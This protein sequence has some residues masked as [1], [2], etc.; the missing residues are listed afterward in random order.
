MRTTST[1]LL[2]CISAIAP[3]DCRSEGAFAYGQYGNG[4]WS[5][6]TSWNYETKAEASDVAMRNCNARGPNCR[7]QTTFHETCFAYAMQD[8]SNGWGTGFGPTGGDASQQALRTCQQYGVRCYVAEQ[9]CDNVSEDG[10]RAQREAERQAR[11]DQEER[12]LRE[13][14]AETERDRQAREQ[15]AREAAERQ[16]LAEEEARQ[17]TERL[18]AER[19]ATEAAEEQ[20]RQAR[21]ELDRLRTERDR[22]ARDAAKPPSVRQTP[23]GIGEVNAMLVI[24]IVLLVGILGMIL[25]GNMNKTL[26]VAIAIIIPTAVSV[27]LYLLGIKTDFTILSIPIAA[28][29]ALALIYTVMG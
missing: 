1:I 23:I 24:V 12:D 6:G 14:W 10:I 7:I 27:A 19:K 22:L 9:F 20:A 21:E 15:Q 18:A 3:A 5:A 29:F 13:R 8:G 2:T 28:G 26:K 16:A 25:K 11:L 4:G 17:Q